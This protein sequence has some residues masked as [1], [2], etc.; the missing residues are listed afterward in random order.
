MEPL[1]KSDSYEFMDS[2]ADA[3]CRVHGSEEQR[4][5]YGLDYK[6]EIRTVDRSYLQKYAE[7]NLYQHTFPSFRRQE[8]KMRVY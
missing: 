3:M 1:F 4:W 5:F 7:D 8:W 6:K 2:M